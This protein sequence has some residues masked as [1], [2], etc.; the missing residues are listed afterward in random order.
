MTFGLL[1]LIV[2]AGLAGPLLS[3]FRRFSIPLVVGEIVAGILLG[4]SGFQLINTAEP[5]LT[6]FSDVGLAMLL[7]LVG[8][9]LP[10]HDPNLRKALKSSLLATVLAFGFSIPA[11]IALSWLTGISA[12]IFVLLLA[13]SSTSAMM[14]MVHE[15]RLTGQTILLTTAWVAL[16]D[17]VTIVALPLA[18]ST[19]KTVHVIV[20]ALVVT[21][22]AL[23]GFLALKVFRASSL[24][25]RYRDLSKERLWALDLRMSLAILFTL[26]WLAVKFGTSILVAGFAAGAVV[27]M[28]GVPRRFTKQLVGIAEGFFVPLFFVVLGAKIDLLALIHSPANLALTALVVLANVAVHVVVARIIKLPVWSGLAAAAEL[29][30]P[31]A[32]VSIG[33]AEN[34][35]QPAQAAAIIAAS[36]CSLIACS[37]GIS[38]LAKDPANVATSDA[39]RKDSPGADDE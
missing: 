1:A 9:H 18:M 11:G 3:G 16:A 22:A 19:G 27:S 25:Q 20:G 24:G 4:K 15:R 35:L 12:P 21:G 36:M 17:A 29:G 7:F 14:P 38:R 31:A 39:G 32:V 34:L 33:L 2:A 28:V 5:T 6:F 10:I 23:G 13:N 26:A 37:V 30:L 8:T